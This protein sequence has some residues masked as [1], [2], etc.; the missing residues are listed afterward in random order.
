MKLIRKAAVLGSGVMGSAIAAHL[1]NAGIDVVLLDI[2]PFEL[3]EEEKAKGLTINDKLV[4]NRIVQSNFDAMLKAKPAALYLKDFAKNIK[5]G[6]F[7]DDIAEIKNCDWVIEVVVENMDIKKKLFIERVLP[8]L[9]ENAVLSTNTSGLSVNEMAQVMPL[10]V[11]KRFMVTHFF[12]PPRYMRLLEIVP[13][14][15]TDPKILQDM[16]DFIEKRL[17]KGI[18]YAKDTANFIANRIGVYFIFSAFKHM[19]N[20]GLTVEEVDAVCGPAIGMPKTAVFKLAD[21]VGID[22]IGHIA[23]NTYTLLPNDEEREIY[24]LP[25]FVKGMIDKKLLGNKTKAGFYKKDNDKKR[26]YYDYNIQDY[27][28]IKKPKFSS[29]ETAK[30]IDDLND[31]IKAVLSGKDKGSQVAWNIL[32]DTFIYTFNRIP[33]IS[34]DVL[35]V[36]NAMKW[37]YNWELGPFEMMDVI[38][39]QNIV[40]RAEK[41]G[42]KV[43]EKLKSIDSFYKEENGK[44]YYYSANGEYKE[45][46]R[47]KENVKLTILKKAGNIVE[48]TSEATLIDLRDGVF[49]L[50]FHTKMN[51]IG[52]GILSMIKKA[53]KRAEEEGVGLVIANEGKNFSAGANLAMLATA[54]SEGAF[55]DIDMMVRM[56][57]NATMAIKYSRV[58]VVSAPFGMTLGGGC[59]VCLHSDVICAYAETYMGLVEVG[60]GLLPAGGGTKELAVRAIQDAEFYGIDVSNLIFKYFQNI[61]QAK[62]SMGAHELYEMGYMRKGDT[63][64]MNLDNLIYDAKQ[65][66][67]SLANNYR[68]KKPLTEL[69]APGRSVASAI[70][71]QLWN[72]MVGNYITEYERYMAGLIADV[73]TG[74][75]VSSGT[76]ITEQYLLDLEREKF[77]K[78]CGQRKTVERILSIL[79]TGKPL[80]N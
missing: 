9:N 37:G 34:D 72:M 43:P 77:L 63:V 50:E 70:K 2:V 4:R 54:I 59:E 31:R 22:T 5:I 29:V 28:E 41:E 40:K 53:T 24:K 7:D 21:L 14:K 39:V 16:A 68:P 32:R 55:E 45:L 64:T 12:N 44:T 49:C 1:A 30:Q 47:K 33:E 56:F 46:V 3:T 52:G 69:K 11:R 8:N 15:D 73:I 79:K 67:L 13:N 65:M 18:V 51:A 60:V 27:V 36:D 57:Q 17:G 76:L 74:G 75:D 48:K 35:N 58:P 66:V 23:K 26:F 10:D 80:R 78:L 61:A 20:M 42:I 25:D 71:S 62:V 19:M 38:G 6:N